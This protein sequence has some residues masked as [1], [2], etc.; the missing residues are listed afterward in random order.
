LY[1][2]LR[3]QEICQLRRA[4]VRKEGQFWVIDVWSSSSNETK[5]VGRLGKWIKAT[6]SARMVPIHPLLIS[7]GFLDFVREQ[8]SEGLFDDLWEGNPLVTTSTY[9]SR[10]F[11]KYRRDVGCHE[12]IEG[13]NSLRYDFAAYS[14]IAGIESSITAAIMGLA[15]TSRTRRQFDAGFT[16]SRL[17]DSVSTICFGFE[18]ELLAETYNRYGE[19]SRAI[20]DSQNNRIRFLLGSGSDFLRNKMKQDAPQT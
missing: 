12:D 14:Y 13:F 18:T 6:R 19:L 17:D 20:R 7:L 2:G 5:T 15:P 4:D 9:F 11:S 8:P 1:G 3:L 10:W 16:I